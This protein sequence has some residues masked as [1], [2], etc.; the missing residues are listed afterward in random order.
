M[1]LHRSPSF[2]PNSPSFHTF[3]PLRN[4]PICIRSALHQSPAPPT[5]PF[6][7]VVG[8]RWS[9]PQV[10]GDG[11]SRGCPF[12]PPPNRPRPLFTP[13]PGLPPSE[14][15]PSRVLVATDPRKGLGGE[16]SVFFFSHFKEVLSV[17]PSFLHLFSSFL[18]TTLPYLPFYSELNDLTNFD[19]RE[20]EVS[21]PLH[22]LY[23]IA[24]QEQ[25]QTSLLCPSDLSRS[26]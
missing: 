2:H 24:P 3:P 5:R 7:Q 8:V 21:D 17:Y 10:P 22:L 6:G 25:F 20:A 1:T 9:A 16:L 18:F 4:R 26:P 23:Q 11:T 15:K 14:V 19:L 13:T 12:E